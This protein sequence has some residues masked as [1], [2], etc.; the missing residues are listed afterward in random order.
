MIQKFLKRIQLITIRS[1][2]GA[3]ATTMLDYSEHTAVGITEL[4]VFTGSIYNRSGVHTR[5]QRDKSLRLRDEFERIAKWAQGVIRKR[6]TATEGE[7]NDAANTFD[8]ALVLSLACLHVGCINDDGKLSSNPVR[9]GGGPFYSFKIIA[10]C[11][12]LKELD[13][14]IMRRTGPYCY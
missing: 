3:I 7:H 5:R 1:Y 2:E 4:E 10:A 9:R 12:A 6:V 13:A 11:C 14:A 8:G